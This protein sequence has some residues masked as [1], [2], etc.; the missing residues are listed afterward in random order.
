M[1]LVIGNKNY[2]SWSL[3][4]W[5]LLRM[6]GLPFEEIR[7]PLAQGTTREA[8]AAH[9]EAGKVPVLHDDELTVWDSLAICEYLS[10]HYLSGAG[11]P[12]SCHERAEARSVSAEMHAGFVEL[13]TCMPMN[14][15]ASGRSVA[16]SDTL[17]AEIMRLE[18]IWTLSRERYQHRGPWLFG[19]FS[20]ADCMFAPVAFR[21]ATYGVKLSPPAEAYRQT[22]LRS[23]PMQEWVEQARAEPEVIESAEVGIN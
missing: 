18:R 15:R 7:I 4:P 13:R 16:I 11:W 12:A 19:E 21:F 17:E 23:A 10:E 5:L 1:K 3:R 6:H 22:L 8:L 2:S 20:I 14:C 9:T